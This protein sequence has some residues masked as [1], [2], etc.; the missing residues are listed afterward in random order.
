M[1]LKILSASILVMASSVFAA[2]L[3]VC[4]ESTRVTDILGQ[5]YVAFNKTPE[6]DRFVK[7]CEGCFN[8]SVIEFD[9]DGRMAEFNIADM[10]F[11]EPYTFCG[12]IIKVKGIGGGLTYELSDDSHQLTD[13][14]GVVYT[15]LSK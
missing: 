10:V 12:D 5:R 6:K 2:D 9:K 7:G 13:G 8:D 1:N 11:Y 3:P 15:L 14:Y 4:E